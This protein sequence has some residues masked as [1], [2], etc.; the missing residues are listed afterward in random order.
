[1]SKSEINTVNVFSIDEEK[2]QFRVNVAFNAANLVQKK[3]EYK[4]LLPI[5]TSIANSHE[6][7]SCR[8]SCNGFQA[9]ASGATADPTFSKATALDKVGSILIQMDIPSS[10]TVSNS[11]NSNLVDK[12]GESSIGGYRDIVMLDCHSIGDGAGNV[13]VSGRS[14]AWTGRS[15]SEP[16]LCGNPFGKTITIQNKD[17]IFD[18]KVWIVSAAAGINSADL[19]RYFYSFD[20]TMIKNN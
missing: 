14:V 11:N 6:Y 5:P 15:F 10:Q 16:I 19:G 18:S 7:N 2:L 3:G 8:I 1:M 9:Y 13:A 17:L 20:I 12:V 4:F